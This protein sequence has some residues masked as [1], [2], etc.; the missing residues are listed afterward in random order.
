MLYFIAGTELDAALNFGEFVDLICTVCCF[1]D[2]ELIKYFFFV[3]NPHRAGFFQVV[4]IFTK[5]C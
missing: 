1:E 4:R 2:T 5:N 3:L